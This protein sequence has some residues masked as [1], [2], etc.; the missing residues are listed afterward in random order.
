M[1]RIPEYESMYHLSPATNGGVK[2]IYQMQVDP[3]G[4]LPK[5]LINMAAA[6]GPYKTM[7]SLFALIESGAYDHVKADYLEE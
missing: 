2:L 4:S 3:G 5:W 6:R 1:I 7:K